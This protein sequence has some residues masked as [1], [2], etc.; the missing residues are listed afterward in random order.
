M[1]QLLCF[2]IL[3]PFLCK[4]QSSDFLI[5]KKKNKT[6]K[7]YYSG[8]NI[9][10]VSTNGAYRNALI[11]AIKND[12]LYLQEFYVVRVPTTIGTYI[13]DTTGSFSFAYHYNQ[14][15]SFGPKK[16]KNFNVSGSGAALMGGGA[17]LTLASGVSYLADK[18][19]FSPGLLAG[20][21][22]LGAI[23]YFI[24]KSAAKNITIGKKYSLTYMDMN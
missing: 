8:S 11:T 24:N 1:K 9:E 3:F 4:A 18:D 14:I 23:G 22:G 19:K 21:I 16:Q 10:F 17:L 12:S 15:H 20:A 2:F 13:L 5:L 6:F 7:Y